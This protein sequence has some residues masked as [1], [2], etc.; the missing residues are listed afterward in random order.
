MI[1]FIQNFYLISLVFLLNFHFFRQNVL[2]FGVA[3]DSQEQRVQASPARHPEALLCR[4]IQPE[5]C[6]QSETQRTRQQEGPRRAAC[7]R[8]KEHPPLCQTAQ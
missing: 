7:Q 3:S 4:E 6:A 1:K 5:S 2:G 8:R